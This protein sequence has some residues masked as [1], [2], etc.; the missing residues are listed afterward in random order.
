VSAP[1]TMTIRETPEWII[2]LEAK[3]ETDSPD[4][5]YDW[6]VCDRGEI[7]EKINNG[8]WMWFQAC[9]RVHHKPTDCCLG[10]SFLGSCCYESLEQFAKTGGYL[11][12]MIRE[13]IDEVRFSLSRFPTNEQPNERN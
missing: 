1:E 5:T 13:A 9:V 7:L 2:E 12:D 4:T 10:S 11:R 8:T 6:S 3:E